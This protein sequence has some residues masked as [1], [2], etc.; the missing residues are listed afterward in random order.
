MCFLILPPCVHSAC[1]TTKFPYFFFPG[2]P[3]ALV[4]MEENKEKHKGNVSILFMTSGWDFCCCCCCFFKLGSDRIDMDENQGI[5]GIPVGYFFAKRP[6]PGQEFPLAQGSPGGD[7]KNSAMAR[8][9]LKAFPTLGIR[10]RAGIS[11]F[12]AAWISQAG[13]F[14]N[15]LFLWSWSFISSH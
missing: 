5:P 1:C 13:Y 2:S 15:S 8:L 3:T 10:W 4:H 11:D 14:Y 6:F 7:R 12:T 9:Y